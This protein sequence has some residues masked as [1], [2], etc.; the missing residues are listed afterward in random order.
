LID[1]LGKGWEN[2]IKIFPWLEMTPHLKSLW[3]II[4]HFQI[5]NSGGGADF[6]LFTELPQHNNYQKQV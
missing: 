2:I 3:I 6:K 4:F 5:A 1:Y